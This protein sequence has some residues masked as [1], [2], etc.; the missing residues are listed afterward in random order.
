[1]GNFAKTIAQNNTYTAF[2]K[3]QFITEGD[4]RLQIIYGPDN[5]RKKTVLYHD[6]N[7][8][9]PAAKTGAN[10]VAYKTRYF[11]GGI[12]KEEIIDALTDN[13]RETT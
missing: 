8:G 10:W 4:Y 3:V 13:T 9:I 6:A 12:Y 11:V 7:A 5:Q 2:N 1:M